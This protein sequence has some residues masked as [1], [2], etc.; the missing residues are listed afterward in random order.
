MTSPPTSTPIPFYVSVAT[1]TKYARDWARKDDITG[2]T[3]NDRNK[4]KRA[5]EEG[6][7]L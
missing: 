1:V 5:G 7:E 3:E 6:V 2:N 4:E